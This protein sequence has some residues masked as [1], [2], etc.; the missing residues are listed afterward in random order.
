M[1][2]LVNAYCT[3]GQPADLDFPHRA[4]SRREVTGGPLDSHLEQFGRFCSDSGNRPLTP[5][6]SLILRHI[7]RTR[8]HYS[9]EI[10]DEDFPALTPWAWQSNAILFLP[11]GSVRDPAG[12]VLVHPQSGN[13]DGRAQLP[14]PVDARQR[15]AQ[16]EVLLRNRL[17]DAPEG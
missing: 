13:P 15:K 12:F 3:V 14:F 1:P 16:S 5:T 8:H 10:Q 4:P 9:F 6:L 17:I 11:D 7:S 2:I